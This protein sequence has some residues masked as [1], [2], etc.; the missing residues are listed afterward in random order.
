MRGVVAGSFNPSNRA[1]GSVE[2]MR[3]RKRGK[4]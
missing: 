4:Q 2:I 1:T 3:C